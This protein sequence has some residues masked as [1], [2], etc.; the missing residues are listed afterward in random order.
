MELQRRHIKI[1]IAG[2]L[3]VGLIGLWGTSKFGRRLAQF[4]YNIPFIFQSFPEPNTVIVTIDPTAKKNLNQSP[5]PLDRRFYT[6]LIHKLHADGA[7]LILF[8]LISFDEPHLD[9]NVDRDFIAAVRAHGKVVLVTYSIRGEQ[10]NL[11]QQTLIEIVPELRNGVAGWGLANADADPDGMIRRIYTGTLD[12][13]TASWVAAKLLQAPVTK[14]ESNRIR[15][16]WLNYY[17]PPGTLKRIYIDHALSE[18]GLPPGTFKDK[19][20]FI[21]FGSEI[22]PAGTTQD[23]FPSPHSQL[24]RDMRLSFGVEILAQST[25]N[26]VRGDWLEHLSYG[27][28]IMII[29]CW[30]I[31]SVLVF[32]GTRP[33]T[34]GALAAISIFAVSSV[35]VLSQLKLHLWWSWLILIVQTLTALGWAI[36]Y[37]YLTESARRRVVNRALA[38]YVSPHMVQRLAESEFDL[39]P[40]GVNVE[41]TVMFTDLEGFTKLSESLPPEEVSKILISYFTQTTES[42][43]EQDGTIIKYI[44]DAVL[45][46]WGAP[47]PDPRQA[48]RAVLAA[49][50][51]SQVSKRQIEGRILRT[52]IGLN[53]GTVL[54]GNLG[55]PKR[56][57]YTVIGDVVNFASRLEG[58]NKYLGTDILISET[59]RSKL[60]DAIKVRALGK[61]RVVGKKLSVGIF[62]V[63]GLS[64]SPAWVAPFERAIQKFAQRQ[65]E[66]AELLFKQTI[67][68]R[69]GADGPSEFYLE[70]IPKAREFTADDWDG[71]V[72]IE[73]K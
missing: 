56:Y 2:I 61:F 50:K 66:E 43:F 45:A 14:D 11:E 49:W 47:L 70:Q 21:G 64:E 41:T 24:I 63:I 18:G 29:L 44:G 7:K 20:V 34:A 38:A 42:I 31:L 71:S 62:E 22:G 53:S 51:M 67:A 57:D 5:D 26:L 40:G 32:S 35:G 73:G 46:V 36:G 59:T 9:P 68:E 58:L 3:L 37:H 10:A 55:S 17:G 30:A 15:E 8:D 23:T 28:E 52:R 12:V 19:V 48:E 69:N 65:F 72:L 27:D 16:R 13:P 4:S 25:M 54:A 6:R 60:T 39:R 1:Y 33:W